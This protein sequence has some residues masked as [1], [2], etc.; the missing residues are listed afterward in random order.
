VEGLCE[1][2]NKSTGSIKCWEILE[3]LSDLAFQELDSV[4]L[5]S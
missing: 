5:V 1:H 2:G 4:D 3:H